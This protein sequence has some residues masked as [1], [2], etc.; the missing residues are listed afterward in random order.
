MPRTPGAA[1]ESADTG[2]YRCSRPRSSRQRSDASSQQRT[3]SGSADY[4]PIPA[5]IACILLRIPIAIGGRGL[6]AELFGVEHPKN[7]YPTY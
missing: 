7:S 2:T 3:A 5:V 1:G 6:C 4:L